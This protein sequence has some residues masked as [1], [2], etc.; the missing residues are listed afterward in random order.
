[1]PPSSASPPFAHQGPLHWCPRTQHYHAPLGA[2][3]IS[4]DGD[5][6]QSHNSQVSQTAYRTELMRVIKTIGASVKEIYTPQLSW[7]TKA[8]AFLNDATASRKC[9]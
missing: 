2:A 5:P 8:D 6:E 9:T 3:P 4:A 1:M 7:F